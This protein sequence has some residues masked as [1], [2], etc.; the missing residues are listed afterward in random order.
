[1]V[2]DKDVDEIRKKAKETTKKLLKEKLPK[3]EKS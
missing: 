1:M 2:S 3:L